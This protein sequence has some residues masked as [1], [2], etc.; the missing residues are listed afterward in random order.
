ML[1]SGNPCVARISLEWLDQMREVTCDEVGREE[2]RA[3]VVD[4]LGG[5]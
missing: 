1:L 3:P 2:S 5:G 4:D